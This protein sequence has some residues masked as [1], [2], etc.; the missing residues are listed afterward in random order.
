MQKD[1]ALKK[2]KQEA[3]PAYSSVEVVSLMDWELQVVQV[4]MVK[5]DPDVILMMVHPIEPEVDVNTVC[6]KIKKR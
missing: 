1:L 6:L 2:A 3:W 5:L 4:P